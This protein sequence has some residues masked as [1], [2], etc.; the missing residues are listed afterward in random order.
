ME[1]RWSK[2]ENEELA[3]I[4]LG[5]TDEE[6]AEHFG[7]T[8]IAI[9]SKRK[10]LDLKRTPW[11]VGNDER[12]KQIYHL[13]TDE[14]LAEM[15]NTTTSAIES[16][17]YK[18]GLKRD[19]KCKDNSIPE[20]YKRCS[21]CE[22]VLKK[23]LF[24]NSKKYVDGLNI[25]CKDC[26]SEKNNIKK[27]KLKE[28]LE[29]SNINKQEAIKVFLDNNNG[30]KIYCRKCGT[31]Y[32]IEGFYIYAKVSKDGTTTINKICRVCRDKS[33]KESKLNNAINRGY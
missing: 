30:K 32:D 11:Y 6:L 15:F 20:G 25:Y 2:A 22:V 23:S 16:R 33:I 8:V 28:E 26:V 4:Y 3:R 31:T 10:K 24:S 18:F 1:G 7:R 29:K 12:F 19:T 27:I 17:R 21:S 5:M 9:K 13:Y 14:E